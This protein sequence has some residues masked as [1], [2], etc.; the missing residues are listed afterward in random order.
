MARRSSR[1]EREEPL[2]KECPS[3]S[4]VKSP[5]VHACPACGFKPE[6]H[7]QVEC[8]DGELIEISGRSRKPTPTEKRTF[9][10]QLRGYAQMHGKTE[11]WVLANFRSRFNEWPHTKHV[12][13]EAPGPEVCGWV[14]SRQIRW[15]HRK[16]AGHAVAA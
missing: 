12:A 16:E 9:Y 4:F 10:A 2:P 5:K 1:D 7:S 13:P 6:R 11:K 8:E 15:A 14:K 3:C